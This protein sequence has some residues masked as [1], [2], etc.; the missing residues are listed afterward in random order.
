ML[1]FV[2]WHH[3]LKYLSQS[4]K[5]SKIKPSLVILVRINAHLISSDVQSNIE[6]KSKVCIFSVRFNQSHYVKGLD[7][8]MKQK[9]WFGLVLSQMA[10]VKKIGG[11]I[12]SNFFF[13]GGFMFSGA[14]FLKFFFENIVASA[15]KSCVIFFAPETWKNHSNIVYILLYWR[16]LL[17]RLLYNDF[18]FNRTLIFHANFGW[19]FFKLLKYAG[20]VCSTT[21]R[22]IMRKVT[23]KFR[24]LLHNVAWT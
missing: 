18:G 11:P 16:H 17:A 12:M 13:G 10:I 7:I 21:Q 2:I 5:L 22:F 4:E 15:L 23:G 3:F 8:F 19:I 20:A 1:R 9:I 14:N 6:R 24:A